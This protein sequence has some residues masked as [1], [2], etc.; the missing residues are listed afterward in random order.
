MCV[1]VCVCVCV[2]SLKIR[3]VDSFWQPGVDPAVLRMRHE[4]YSALRHEKMKTVRATRS[5]LIAQEESGGSSSGGGPK[6]F[7]V[8][9]NTTS[10]SRSSAL[11]GA[12]ELERVKRKQQ[13]ELEAMMAY[14]QKMQQIAEEQERKEV[15]CVYPSALLRACPP[16]KLASFG[17]QAL[18]KQRQE[19]ME[20][21][22]VLAK[23][24]AEE[25]RRKKELK[26]RLL[27]E[28]EEEKRKEFMR[29]QQEKAGFFTLATC[30]C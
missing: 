5:E 27:E 14:E 28:A 3:S 6:P 20:R 19:K 24:K 7:K 2:Q 17:A 13:K 12:D 11:V 21:E 16:W 18:E 15:G 9:G 29:Q 8:A 30:C 23:K 10:R 1:C 26:R 4:A 25:I 22:K